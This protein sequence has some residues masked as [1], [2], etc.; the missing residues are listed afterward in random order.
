MS[1]QATCYPQFMSFDCFSCI[2]INKKE[3]PIWPLSP[4]PNSLQNLPQSAATCHGGLSSSYPQLVGNGDGQWGKGG[5]WK[6][7]FRIF[8]RDWHNYHVKVFIYNVDLWFCLR[9]LTLLPNHMTYCGTT[10]CFNKVFAYV[11]RDNFRDDKT[12]A[13]W[14]RL[15]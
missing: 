3:D 14:I 6:I 15:G 2:K 12:V 5:L 7:L 8:R 10:S 9:S 4:P 13:G 11:F 1:H